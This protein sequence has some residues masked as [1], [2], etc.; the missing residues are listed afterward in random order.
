MVEISVLGA[1]GLTVGGAPAELGGTRQRAVLARL[2]AARGQLVPVDRL[3]ADLWVD[4]APPRALGGIQVFVSHLRRALEPGRA[5]RTPARTLVTAPPGYALRL[6]AAAVDAWR[7]EDLITAESPGAPGERAAAY[8]AALGLWRGPAYAEFAELPWAATEAARLLELR[9]T[10]VERR[11]AAL[12]EAGAAAAVVAELE[13]HLADHP[14][15]EEPWRLLALALYRCGRQADALGALRRVR[16]VLATELGVDPGQPLRTLETDILTQAPHLDL[17]AGPIAAGPAPAIETARITPR[18]DAGL[19]PD[20]PRTE[21]FF[22]RETELAALADAARAGVR[23]GLIAGDPGAGKT[24]L[25]RRLSAALAEWTP[26]W[27]RTPE[28]GAAPA[29]WAWGEVLRALDSRWPVTDSLLTPLLAG[30]NTTAELTDRADGTAAAASVNARRVAGTGSAAAMDRGAAPAATDPMSRWHST[31]HGYST[32]PAD[33]GIRAAAGGDPASV[34]FHTHRALE[35]YLS[36]VAADGPLLV[37]LEDLHRADE[38]TLSLLAVLPRRVPGIFVVATYRPGESPSG[39]TGVLGELAPVEPVRI[40]LDGL[41]E[42][43]VAQLVRACC[44]EEVTPEVVA[45]ICERTGGNPFFVRETARLLAAAGPEAALQEVP[46]G[47]ADVLR[48]RIARLPAVAQTVLRCAAVAGRD[49]DVDLLA[50]VT[51]ESEDTVLDALEAGGLTGLLTEHTDTGGQLWGVRFTHVLIRDALYDSISRLRRA[52]IHGRVADVLA[53]R[54]GIDP[55]RLAQHCMASGDPARLADVVEYSCRAAELAESRFAHRTAVGL[56]EQALTAYD[57]SEAGLVQGRAEQARRRIELEVA[58]IRSCALS[59]D[60]IRARVLR[61]RALAA[62][63]RLGD[64]LLAARVIT[65]FDVPTLW[66]NRMYGTRETVVIDAAE[67]ALPTVTEPVLR[68]RLLTSLAMQLDSESGPRGRE[69][70][71]EAVAL[72]RAIGRPDLL[73]H[74][75]NGRYLNLYHTA[76]L[77]DEQHRVAEEILTLATAHGLGLYQ[78]LGHLLL[79]QVMSARLDPAAADHWAQG[80]RLAED[81]D[82]PLLGKIGDW[83]KCMR[84]TITGRF[85]AAE[86]A[87]LETAARIRG[88]STFGGEVA[89]AWV[90]IY[91]IRYA[92]GRLGELVDDTLRLHETLGRLTGTADMYALALLE[93]GRTEEAARAVSAAAGSHGPGR[94]R[95][96][97]HRDLHLS[98]RGLVAAGLG[99]TALAA[100]TYDELSPYAD[101]FAGTMSAA[102]ALCPVALVLGDLAA[103]LGRDDP[104]AHYTR[105]AAVARTAG[106][107]HW[108]LAAL[109][110][111]RQRPTPGR[112]LR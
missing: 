97:F 78:V 67:A 98:I 53:R 71:A 3:I 85:A 90:G 68:A 100:P 30:T 48:R 92:Q 87:Y 16:Q 70:A 94:V 103:L 8:G 57:R 65:G 106:A 1:F 105:A 2:V 64:P 9:G 102:L 45:A 63:L 111:I 86:S 22:G 112:T 11:A 21:D 38:E 47:V 107:E 13:A 108:E 6:P 18:T 19:A 69:A 54:P 61:D 84:H 99:D 27:G 58:R 10:A 91:T 46:S 17:P 88:G 110:R 44:P 24:T 34:R 49:A 41:A 93:A 15:R 55:A 82:L 7:F 74:A 72:A 80:T 66:I 81:M 75:L 109:N 39:L 73:A 40:S 101:R 50:A 14:L 37:V 26:A 79:Q 51:G 52:R 23:V 20:S 43:A 28:T 60:I 36:A 25:A 56:W 31:P 4:E 42:P 77:L 35:R 33:H 59:G 83:G 95:A 62:A 104:R 29:G 32:R 76:D 5:P 89:T 12:L 96:D